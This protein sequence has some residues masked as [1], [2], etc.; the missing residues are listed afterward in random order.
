MVSELVPVVAVLS[1]KSVGP[2]FTLDFLIGGLHLKFFVYYNPQKTGKKKKKMKPQER[3][4][5]I[6]MGP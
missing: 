4:S 6:I 5:L 3:W 1:V 2:A